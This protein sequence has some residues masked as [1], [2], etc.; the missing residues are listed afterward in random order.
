M[1]K[2]TYAFPMWKGS[3]ILLMAKMR[4]VKMWM[5]EL[6]KERGTVGGEGYSIR[7]KD[8]EAH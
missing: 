5:A 7:G 8:I 6:W 3:L 2:S 1:K 4:I